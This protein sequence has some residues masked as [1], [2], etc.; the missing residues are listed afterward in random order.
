MRIGVLGLGFM[1]STHLQAL[2][3]IPGVEVAAVM[4]RNEKRLAGDMSDIQGNLGIPGARIDLSGARKY[5]KWESMI[6]DRELDAID[7]CLPT[8]LHE[9]VATA[10][11]SAG[12]DVLVEKPMALGGA[13][14]ARMI[15]AAERNSRVLMVAHVLRFMPPYRELI[16]L[17][18][19]GRLGRVRS[20]LFR[21]RTAVPTWGAWEFDSAQ[22]GGGVFDLLIHDVDIALELFGVPSNIASTGYENMRG[23]VDVITSHFDVPGADSLTITG[24]WHHVG[25][26]PFSMEYTILA[27]NGAVEFSSA[28]RPA[29]VYWKDGTHEVLPAADADPYQAEITYFL[30]CCRTRRR[31]ALCPA[32]ASARA[33]AV[34]RRMVDARAFSSTSPRSSDILR[35]TNGEREDP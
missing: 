9:P 25:D 5:R 10:A 35:P 17:V 12:R 32:D 15:D 19:S 27:D 31:P 18:R 3:R 22:S 29:A 1:G 23:G 14:A 16:A 20:A 7:I 8:N 2:V 34:A 24:G 6:A 28:G 13:S 11:L 4:S 21:R 26:Y 33:V 30:E